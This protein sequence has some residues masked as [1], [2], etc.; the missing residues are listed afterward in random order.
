MIGEDKNEAW[1]IRSRLQVSH[2]ASSKRKSIRDTRIAQ[3]LLRFARTMCRGNE[4]LDMGLMP[5]EVGHGRG[6]RSEIIEMRDVFLCCMK[7][8]WDLEHKR[9]FDHHLGGR[10]M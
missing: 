8:E 5:R 3:P 9:G 7:H 6:M 10:Y 1:E 4:I 2:G